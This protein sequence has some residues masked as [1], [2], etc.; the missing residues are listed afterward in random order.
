MI[1]PLAA[2]YLP[3]L[4]AVQQT[5]WPDSPLPS[6]LAA[7]V[8][9]ESCISPTHSKCWSP[10]A[11]LKTSREYGFGVGQITRAYNADGSVRFDKFSELR[12]A[13]ASLRAW[14]WENRYDARYQFIA[15]VEMDKAIYGRVAG[16][17]TTL[18]RLAFTLAAY[19]GGEGGVMQDRT[20]CRRTPG[21]D[22]ARWYGHVEHRSLKSR[23]KWKGY[24]KSA[25]EI[26]REYVHNILVVRRPKYVPHMGR[27]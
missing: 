22:A 26:N 15:L 17:G 1:P 14:T 7:Q 6:M 2:I 11:E 18:D 3:V 4:L 13:H 8:E 16:A 9:Q 27:A 20:L 19:N 12:A 21:C 10:R 25:F 24:G 23:T 5:V